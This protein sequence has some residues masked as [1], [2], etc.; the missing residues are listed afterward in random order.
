MN[1]I[2]TIR[3]LVY[4]LV[5]QGPVPTYRWL[6]QEANE[7]PCYVVGRPEVTEGAQRAIVSVSVPVYVIGRT[8]AGRD[9]DTQSEL[10]ALADA[11][12][13]LLWKPPQTESSSLRLTR[14]LPTVV[15][16]AATDFPA[17]T[18]TCVA[19]TTFC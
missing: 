8:A 10:D 18:A 15:P 14:M 2:S 1:V 7:V 6:P 12:L 11:L 19:S 9:D 17:Y 3:Q 13:N 5:A 16:I 4:G